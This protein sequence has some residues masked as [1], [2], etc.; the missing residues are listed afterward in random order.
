VFVLAGSR[1][2]S[3]D[4]RM[5]QPFSLDIF[6][7]TSTRGHYAG[8]VVQRRSDGRVLLFSVELPAAGLGI[9]TTGS[10]NS[11]GVRLRALRAPTG[12]TAGG[13]A[14]GVGVAAPGTRFAAGIYRITLV[15]DGSSRLTVMGSSSVPTLALRPTSR[16]ATNAGYDA[17]G[18]AARAPAG[19]ARVP[20]TIGRSLQRAIAVGITEETGVGAGY[21]NLCIT[22]AP[23]CEAQRHGGAG[24]PFLFPSVGTIDGIWV[25]DYQR[26]TTPVGSDHAVFEIANAGVGRQLAL[27]AIAIQ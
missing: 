3:V 4:V 7:A 18:V 8:L 5:A 1:T 10:P 21:G 22:K 12:A 27:F 23:L 11:R 19:I 20:L 24:A 6:P 13:R 15:T 17:A 16:T 9:A 26:G 2:A 14:S 25:A